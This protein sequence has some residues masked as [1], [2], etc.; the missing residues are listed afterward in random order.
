MK[1]LKQNLWFNSN[2][3]LEHENVTI[4]G[5]T[6][7]VSAM[8]RCISLLTKSTLENADHCSECESALTC[9]HGPSQQKSHQER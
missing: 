2:K 8:D 7:A 1:I 9:K 5:H 3:L 6:S 4:I